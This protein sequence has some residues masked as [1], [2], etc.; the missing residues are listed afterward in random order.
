MDGQI[1][2]GR[3]EM[4]VRTVYATRSPREADLE[5][6]STMIVEVQNEGVKTSLLGMLDTGAGLNVMSVSA[7]RR[8]REPSLTPLTTAIK[9]ANDQPIRVFGTTP[10]MK[11]SIASLELSTSFV[12]VED[13]GEDD[14]LLG[15]TLYWL[16][17]NATR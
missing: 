5:A 6:D 8:M 11:M 10:K 15:R 3:N 2:L 7:W 16:T 1:C 4:F 13:L 14:F 12:V 17:S 9:M